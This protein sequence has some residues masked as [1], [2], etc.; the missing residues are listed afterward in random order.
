MSVEQTDED[1]QSIGVTLEEVRAE[2]SE[3]GIALFDAAQ[4]RAI[5]RKLAARLQ[6]ALGRIDALERQRVPAADPPAGAARPIP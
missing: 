3:L 5:N 1:A 4:T 6:D 2:M